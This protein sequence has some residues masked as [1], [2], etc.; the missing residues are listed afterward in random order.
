MIGN[1]FTAKTGWRPKYFIDL[2]GEKYSTL[3]YGWMPH[4]L[5]Q[6]DLD[7]PTHD[8]IV[9]NPDVEVLPANLNQTINLSAVQTILSD[10]DI[11]ISWLNSSLTYLQVLRRLEA[12]FNF[13]RKYQGY[14]AHKMIRAVWVNDVTLNQLPG[15]LVSDLQ[16]A[17]DFFSLDTTGITG[18]TTVEELMVNFAAQL[19]S[20]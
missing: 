14:L 5:I 1:G 13:A 17:A 11:P 16:E 10:R 6:A 20:E 2:T 3:F 4:A 18:T 9:A 19:A 12:L 8:S 7:Q 15:F